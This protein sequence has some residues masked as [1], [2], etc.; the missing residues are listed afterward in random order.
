DESLMTGEP[1]PITRKPG[2][3]VLGG[4]RVVEGQVEIQVG[5]V[6]ESQMAN[7]ARILWNAQSSTPGVHGI[8]D[9]IVRVFVPVVL[10]F[11][12]L[13]TAWLYLSGSSLGTALLAGMATLIVSCP[14]TFGLA[15]PLTTA[16]GLSTGLR[17]GIIFTNTDIFE[18]I[19]QINTIAIDKTGI[20]S[21]GK[22]TVT[23]VIGALKVKE[24][25]AAVERLSPHPI[26]EAIARLDAKYVASDVDIRPGKGAI[27]TVNGDR[28]VVGSQ[29]LFLTLGW[30][31]PAHLA[32]SVDTTISNG[33]VI[34]YVGW[35]HHI[36]G[37][38]FTHDQPRPDWEHVVD[39]L[40][41]NSRVTLLTGAEN[42]GIYG[43]RMD[44]VFAGIPPEAKAAVI[45]QLK[46]EGTVVMI[47]DGSN[48]APALASADLGI[49][50]GAPTALAADAADVVIPGNQL[51]KIFTVF[52][53]IRTIRLRV[54][55]N[56]GWALLY[57]ATAIPLAISGLL[58]PLFAALA[59]SAS[60][61]LVIWNSTRSIG[62]NR[63]PI[64]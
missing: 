42:A 54:R 44:Q 28:V 1:F 7:L 5:H 58:N 34:S 59:M 19:L 32:T 10:S 9:R 29:S 53:L 57:N 30:D 12:V 45:R 46:S 8:A 13:L 2:E 39:E 63:Q 62:T 50:F 51:E 27:A 3:Q 49:A 11:A 37:A 47:G 56:L 33:G 55:Q 48:D 40:Q 35:D 23:E 31:I 26:A 14:C 15:I 16:V 20:L 52:E 43:V 22:M 60:S 24:Y 41:E 4:T 6:V 64:H 18:K 17:N 21:T 38:I 61:L 25:A 36:N